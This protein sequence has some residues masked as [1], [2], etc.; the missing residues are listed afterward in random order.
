VTFASAELEGTS[1][2][3]ARVELLMQS[4]AVLTA[5]RVAASKRFKVVAAAEIL[6]MTKA[7]DE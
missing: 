2:G 3:G 7:S 1:S 6:P 5:P 4:S